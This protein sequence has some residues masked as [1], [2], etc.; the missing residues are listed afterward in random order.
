VRW[1]RLSVRTRTA[2]ASALV[3]APVLAA[4]SVAGVVIQR[5]DLTDSVTLVAR[6]HA[7]AVARQLENDDTG[8]EHSVAVGE[9]DLVQVVEGGQVTD[10]SDQLTG[11]PP[12]VPESSEVSTLSGLADGEEDRY[13][14]VAAPVSGQDAY[15][16]SARSLESVDAAT[17][18]TTRLL[19][20]GSVLVIVLVFGLT[21]VLT[22]RALRPVEGMRQRAAGITTA[23]LS[24]RLP[25]PATGDEVAR[26]ADT[27]NALLGRVEH[28]VVA[29]R[30]FVADASHELRSPI[31]TIRILHETAHLSAHPGGPAGLSADVLREVTRLEDLVADL[32]LLARSESRPPRRVRVDLVAEATA[33]AR[34]PRRRPVLVEGPP[35]AWVH[36]DPRALSRVVRNLLDNADRHAST[37]VTVR[38]ENTADAVRVSVAD[39]GPGIPEGDRERIFDRFVRLDE[40]RARDDGGSG[41]GLAIVRQVVSDHGGTVVVEPAGPGATVTV[42]L[43]RPASHRRS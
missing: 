40:A 25:S 31:A 14:V 22:G 10:A 39:D 1:P 2:L 36:G 41:L 21:W 6:E 9:E 13:I 38:V 37:A 12:L 24:A 18:S 3:V 11:R 30:R 5:H 19:L 4:A 34:Q 29:Q 16:V 33:L 17:A 27:M 23:D 7:A 8:N 26:L 43:P 28:A 15:V 35:Q 42:T 32:L 20:I